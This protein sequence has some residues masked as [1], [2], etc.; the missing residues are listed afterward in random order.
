MTSPEMLPDGPLIGFVCYAGCFRPHWR[1]VVNVGSEVISTK[2]LHV[3]FTTLVENS[4]RSPERVHLF[5]KIE[6]YQV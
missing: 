6:K 2:T 3:H 1:S 5:Q 4:P